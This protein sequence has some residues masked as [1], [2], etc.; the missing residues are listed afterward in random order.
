MRSF[1][2]QCRG[3]GKVFVKLVRQTEQRLLDLNESIETWTQ[4]AKDLLDQDAKLSDAQL[5]RVAGHL[6]AARRQL[7]RSSLRVCGP[8]S[9]GCDRCR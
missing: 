6:D 3:Q 8:C 9:T 2:R 5:D 1:G 7:L 4:E